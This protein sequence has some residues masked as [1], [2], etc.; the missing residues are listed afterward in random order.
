LTLLEI[1]LFPAD[2]AAEKNPQVFLRIYLRI[3]SLRRIT[4]GFG[5]SSGF[6]HQEEFPADLELSE[7]SAGIPE[8]F[9]ADFFF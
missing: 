4:Y 1:C 7:K 6:C 3:W 9:P 8:N 5:V 2:F